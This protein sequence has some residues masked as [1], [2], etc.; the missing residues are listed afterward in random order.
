MELPDVFKVEGGAH[1]QS[2]EE[3]RLQGIEPKRQF[4]ANPFP[5]L[6]TALTWAAPAP[7]VGRE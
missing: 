5:D 1:V 3:W 4:D 7:A 2:P 6:E